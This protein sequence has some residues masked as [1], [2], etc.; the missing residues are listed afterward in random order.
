MCRDDFNL[1]RIDVNGNDLVWNNGREPWCLFYILF[2]FAYFFFLKD[3]SYGEADA[4]VSIPVPASLSISERTS[5]PPASPSPQAL[6]D[7]LFDLDEDVSVQQKLDVI[8]VNQK[9]LPV[10]KLFSSVIQ[11]SLK[12]LFH[13]PLQL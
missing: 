3:C 13:T 7:D 1:Y 2:T 8:I 10:F 4:V 5:P 6:L 11:K 9:A 12:A